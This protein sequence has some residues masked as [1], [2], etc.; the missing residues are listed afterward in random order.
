MH[1][2]SVRVLVIPIFVS[3]AGLAFTIGVVFRTWSWL[4]YGV[5]F[6]A[7]LVALL[8]ALS[9]WRQARS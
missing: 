5:S 7:F 2:Y 9:V 1:R 3:I 6:T 8:Q 4:L